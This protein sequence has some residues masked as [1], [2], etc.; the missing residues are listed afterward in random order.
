M[1]MIKY[2]DKKCKKKKPAK[3]GNGRSIMKYTVFKLVKYFVDN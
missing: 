1:Q 2:H 3:A